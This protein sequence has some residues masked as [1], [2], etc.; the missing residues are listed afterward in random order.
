MSVGLPHRIHQAT[1]NGEANC[2]MAPGTTTV[3]LCG[4]R[5]DM[6]DN[7]L[8]THTKAAVFQWSYFFLLEQRRPPHGGLVVQ[9]KNTGLPSEWRSHPQPSPLS[10]KGFEGRL[11]PGMA[12]DIDSKKDDDGTG[13]GNTLCPRH[14]SRTLSPMGQVISHEPSLYNSS[15]DSG[16]AGRN[17]QCSPR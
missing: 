12:L 2:I 14:L 4:R 13:H 1:G 6:T 17:R 9:V 3:L 7:R 11:V 5:H 8:W 15:S 10:G 16:Y